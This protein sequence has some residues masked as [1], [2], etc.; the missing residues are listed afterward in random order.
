[1]GVDQSKIKF[2]SDVDGSVSKAWDVTK[3]YSGD[4]LG[5]RSERFSMVVDGGVVTSFQVVD[6]AAKDGEWV[7]SQL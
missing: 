1:M 6:D 4:S 7:L 3:D 5:I 2:V